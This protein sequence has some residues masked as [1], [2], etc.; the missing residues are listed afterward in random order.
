M[1]FYQ[2]A[3]S[4]SQGVAQFGDSNGHGKFLFRGPQEYE[5][6]AEC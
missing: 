5:R 4:E 3:K 2:N 6:F 1:R